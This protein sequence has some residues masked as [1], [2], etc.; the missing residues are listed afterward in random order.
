M[1]LQVVPDLAVWLLE[2]ILVLISHIHSNHCFQ[3]ILH[4]CSDSDRSLTF[5][6]SLY[7]HYTAKNRLRA[8][9]YAVKSQIRK[10]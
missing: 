4:L 8:I 3:R 2:W 10:S 7:I 1:V 5:H 9:H 6:E